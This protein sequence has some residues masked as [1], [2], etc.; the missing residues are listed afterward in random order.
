MNA[1][2]RGDVR[3]L[4][5]ISGQTYLEHRLVLKIISGWMPNTSELFKKELSI[6]K[7]L[8]GSFFPENVPHC[9]VRDMTVR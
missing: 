8:H 1:C 2:E 3:L 9:N 6:I 7:M 5:A 4:M